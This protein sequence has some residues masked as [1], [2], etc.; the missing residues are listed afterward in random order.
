M[1][2]TT[3]TSAHYHRVTCRRPP[4]RAQLVLPGQTTVA[5]PAPLARTTEHGEHDNDVEATMRRILAA[6]ALPLLVLAGTPAAAAEKDDRRKKQTIT[7]SQDQTST[8]GS[9]DT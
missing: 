4:P 9:P 6:L 1:A 8:A 7:R 2:A 3:A 5:V